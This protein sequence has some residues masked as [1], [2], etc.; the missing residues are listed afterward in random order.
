METEESHAKE[1]IEEDLYDISCIIC[2][3][4]LKDIINDPPK[5]LILKIDLKGE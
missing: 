2:L 3:S 5:A 1:H 4:D